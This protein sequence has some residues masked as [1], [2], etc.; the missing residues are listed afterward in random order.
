MACN[1]PATSLLLALPDPCLLAVMQCC[2]ADSHRSFFSASRA[3]SRLR[4]MAMASL[5]SITAELSQ[6]Q[7]MDSVLLCLDTHTQVVS[8]DLG[9]S[10]VANSYGQAAVSLCRLPPALQLHSLQLSHLQI[11]LQPEGGFPGVLGAAASLASLTRLRLNVCKLLGT[12][13]L[14][15]AALANL[16]AGLEH[17][18]T[19]S[20]FNAA[21]P[22][23]MLEQ[24]QQLTFLELDGITV[25]GQ[26]ED[27]PALQPLQAMTRLADLRVNSTTSVHGFACADE[28]HLNL[29][30][31]MLSGAHRLTRLELSAF[32]SV[33]VDVLAGRPELSAAPSTPGKPPTGCNC[34]R[35]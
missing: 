33:E 22:T 11:Q 5:T 23:A 14:L 18:S 9:G 1:D 2:A 13:E 29:T 24:L 6:Q 17:L 34:T 15:A 25:R 10:S 7:Q 12:E 26:G 4:Q 20:L 31:S 21:V 28:Y 3:H 19:R 32:Y 27:V 8:I 35:R 30:A 16:P